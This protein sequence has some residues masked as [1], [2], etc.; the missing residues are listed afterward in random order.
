[1]E[2]LVCPRCD[3]ELEIINKKFVCP[4]CD[5]EWNELLKLTD[6]YYNDQAVKNINPIIAAEYKLIGELI[7]NKQ[8]YGIIF[9]IKD[10]YEIVIRMPVLVVGAMIIKRE[11]SF[12]AKELLYY[13]MSKPLSLGDWRYLL[14]LS[15][16]VAAEYGDFPKEITDILSA[17]KKFAN[18]NK[19][20]DIVFWRNNT[21]AH[22]ATKLIDDIELYNDMAQKLKELTDFFVKNNSLFTK[23][24]FVYEEGH[25]LVKD[26]SSQPNGRLCLKVGEEFIPLYPFF[27]L[28]N[29]GIYLF[30]RYLQKQQKTDV[31]E[32][33]R[34][35]KQ[36]V[37]IN[38]LNNLF[39]ENN[40]INTDKTGSLDNYSVEE[41]NLC[42]EFLSSGEYLE[43]EYLLNDLNRQLE[44]E[45]SVFM[46]RMER[47]MGKSFFV[48]GLD[49]F[50]IDKIYLDEVAVKTFYINST[51]NSRIDD[52]SICVED[53]MRKISK[54]NTLA[55][56]TLR[57]DINA[58]N[59]AKEFAKFLNTYKQKCYYDKK[60]LFI[61]DGI[62]EINVQKG[63][64][65]TDFI[66]SEEDLDDG[67]YIMVTCRTDDKEDSLSMF[68]KNY[69]QTFKGDIILYNKDN[70]NY[71]NFVKKYFDLYIIKKIILMCK[72]NN[73]CF[74]VDY[75]KTDEIFESIDRKT[76]LNLNLIKELLS[77]KVNSLINKNIS[78]L[79]VEE[80]AIDNNIYENYF[81][82]I[83]SYYGSKYY[84]KFI[85]VLCCL[86]MADRPLTLKELGVISENNNVNFAYLG[87]I[88][89]MKLFL[90]TIR[91]NEG[92][93]FKIAHLE[94]E[95]VIKKVFA[96]EI[97]DCASRL[98]NKIID[99]S[100]DKFSFATDNDDRIYFCCIN[101]VIG[102]MSEK[103]P[104]MVESL[105]DAVLR[106]PVKLGWTRNYHEV[107]NEVDII[108]NIDAF[109]NY[110]L[111]LDISQLLKLGKLYISCGLD[112]MIVGRLS[113]SDYYFH[114]SIDI[115]K[116]NLDKCGYEELY[117]YT[118]LLSYYA[119][120]K[121]RKNEFE[122]AYNVY[123]ESMDIK[124]DIAN[125][126]NL[127]TELT[128]LFEY[129][130]LANTA[131]YAKKYNEQQSIL[132]RVFKDI[133]KFEESDY[134]TRTMAFGRLCWHYYYRD[135]NQNQ[136]AF[137]AIVQ[138]I[139]GYKTCLEKNI[140]FY[141]PDMVTAINCML[142]IISVDKLNDSEYFMSTI[143]DTEKLIK[144]FKAEYD[145]NDEETY[146]DYLM[147]V[148][149]CYYPFDIEKAKE[150]KEKAIA[151]YNSLENDKK[152][153]V[154]LSKIIKEYLKK[155]PL[156]E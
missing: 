77:L 12:K 116:P 144:K 27:S 83:K 86:A 138:A 89:S 120:L 99:V 73:V 22:G 35:Q 82:N 143:E 107:L 101:S 149:Y 151:L 38:E 26:A 69:V 67:I 57:L 44:K 9:Q 54:G 105:L 46:L 24:A 152:E 25:E 92:T 16:E 33:V 37:T 135:T 78:E 84:Q 1:M 114:K 61:F 47:G 4:L 150:Y 53:Q 15:N 132:S 80:L 155:M 70:E 93:Q 32:Y 121:I 40:I 123:S 59:P 21:I 87:F 13:M 104:L 140:K 88:N 29:R 23:V 17:T 109:F 145:Y 6:K 52:F 81:K 19:T 10:L 110:G 153:N 126:G 36:S 94:L 11:Q 51:Y 102:Y 130:C 5:K 43:P 154:N 85:N 55:N 119:T 14:N 98:A 63:K 49:P 118:E 137:E 65:I 108:K 58:E 156:A 112:D 141:I 2:R 91:S 90:G 103:N 72:R 136:K 131:N 39:I 124:H 48:R 45:K 41:R 71:R 146:L 50:S 74:N 148:A 60:L 100:N 30:D 42:E 129:I 8:V 134:K 31:I 127:F 3:E 128:M 66:P 147:S 117:E 56:N 142:K 111:K 96:E 18:S 76:I 95:K 106:L 7:D 34:S 139:D 62:D 79:K 20:G 115:Y 113:Q 97:R 122:E 64:N 28:R 125:K 68:C 75:S 133:Q